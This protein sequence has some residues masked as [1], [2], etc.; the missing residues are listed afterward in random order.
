MDGILE[1]DSG[2][3]NQIDARA[4]SEGLKVLA[5]T[6]RIVTVAV[7]CGFVIREIW[8]PELD[9]VR[10]TYSDDPDGGPLNRPDAGWVENFR[11]AFSRNRPQPV[12][13]PE[14]PPTPE[15]AALAG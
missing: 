11:R 13:A 4:H 8:R 10:Q 5:A 1:L 3:S 2:I 12:E 14:P 15:P 9:V 6:L 7:L